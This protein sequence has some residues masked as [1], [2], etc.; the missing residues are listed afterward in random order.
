MKRKDPQK[1]IDFLK[2]EG[3]ERKDAK[4]PGRHSWTSAKL[5]MPPFGQGYDFFSDFGIVFGGGYGYNTPA[6]KWVRVQKKIF[7]NNQ[8]YQSWLNRSSKELA[9]V[10]TE[11]RKE[12][13]RLI[14]A[15]KKKH[16]VKKCSSKHDGSDKLDE[17]TKRYAEL[18]NA[19]PDIVLHSHKVY[20]LCY[21]VEIEEVMDKG[22]NSALL[23]SII[24]N[25]E[26]LQ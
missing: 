7:R 10:Q 16:K 5:W 13:N 8:A 1:L 19:N 11:I 25:L 21:D 24:F 15:Y 20:Y 2:E 17:L 6:F 9:E 23:N 18:Q 26:K 14:R 3:W 22:K 4:R 12:E